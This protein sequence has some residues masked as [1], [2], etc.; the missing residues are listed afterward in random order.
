MESIGKLAYYYHAGVREAVDI[1]LRGAPNN[2]MRVNDSISICM[3]PAFLN[4]QT[5]QTAIQRK[6]P[7][8]GTLAET[9]NSAY[10]AMMGLADMSPCD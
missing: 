7:A 3:N 1:L 5:I 8:E 4:T 6:L 2:E 9:V 10:F